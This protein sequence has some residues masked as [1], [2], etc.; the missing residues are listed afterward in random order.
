MKN[1]LYVV[2]MTRRYLKS[3]IS[4]YIEIYFKKL[5]PVFRDIESDTDKYKELIQ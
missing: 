4:D 3:E 2:E 1:Q 5:L